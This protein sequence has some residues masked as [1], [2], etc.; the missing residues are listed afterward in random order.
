MEAKLGGMISTFPQF[1]DGEIVEKFKKKIQASFSKFWSKM[2][3][4]T[5]SSQLA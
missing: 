2:Q 3:S 4:K 1:F 5:F